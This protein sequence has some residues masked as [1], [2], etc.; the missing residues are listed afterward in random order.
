M[1]KEKNSHLLDDIVKILNS[2]VEITRQ[3]VHNHLSRNTGF[4]TTSNASDQPAHTAKP[5]ISLRI[6]AV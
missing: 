1:R 3:H 6:R 4:P 2:L 5:Q